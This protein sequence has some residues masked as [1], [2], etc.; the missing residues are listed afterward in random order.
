[1]S[2]FQLANATAMGVQS[3]SPTPG[4]MNLSQAE[5]D[6]LVS[7][8][9]AQWAAAGAS[10]DQIAL[11]R[12]THFTAADL[13]GT[14]LS[15][16]SSP[17]HVTI[18][19]DAAGHGW[20][21]DPTPFDNLEFPHAQDAA[22]THLL[23]DPTSDAAGHIDLLTVVTRE[24]GYV[25][26]LNESM[27]PGDADDLMYPNLADGERRIPDAI[28]IALA[29][30]STLTPTIS[31][32]PVID[33][34]KGGGFLFGSGSADTFAFANVDV[35]AVLPPA[36]THVMDYHFAEG[37]RFEFSALTPQFHSTGFSDGM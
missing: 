7:A 15:E 11:L 31:L 30:T 20:F 26:G 19:I 5:L 34:D 16:T 17:G 35:H 2:G 18:D 6:A 28:D 36:I 9:I 10:A 12:G 22:G 37:D 13:S 3:S 32:G 29:P 25:L 24:L 4:E 21:I 1:M 8:A 23:T 27:S 33:A 14:A